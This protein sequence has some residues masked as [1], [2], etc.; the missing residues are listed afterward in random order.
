VRLGIDAE[1][2]EVRAIEGAR[3][4]A[5]GP[6]AAVNGS[7]VGDGPML[8]EPLARIPPDEVVGLVTAD[9]AY[10]YFGSL[11]GTPGV[12]RDSASRMGW[13]GFL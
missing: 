4:R 3:A 2:L 11:K 5:T 10:H 12:A 13:R 9:G 8:P 7:G 6:R 1:T